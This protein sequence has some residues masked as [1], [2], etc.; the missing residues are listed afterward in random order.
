M[1]RQ[2]IF[3]ALGEDD[4]NR[5]YDIDLSYKNLSFISSIKEF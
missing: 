4:V 5:I 2:Q 3:E 1:N